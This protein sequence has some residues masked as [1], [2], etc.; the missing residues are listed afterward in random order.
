MRN[1]SFKPLCWNVNE[2][3]D[4]NVAIRCGCYQSKKTAGKYTRQVLFV[5]FTRSASPSDIYG[6]LLLPLI[7]LTTTGRKKALFAVSHV[8]SHG[9]AGFTE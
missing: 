9:I 7:L 6:I 4:V 5:L 1:N 8:Y 2:N 3:C